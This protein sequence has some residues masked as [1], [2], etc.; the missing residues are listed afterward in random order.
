M[1]D[2]VKNYPEYEFYEEKIARRFEDKDKADAFLKKIAQG[3]LSDDLCV[4]PLVWKRG[5]PQS[6][7]EYIEAPYEL[8]IGIHKQDPKKAVFFLVNLKSSQSKPVSNS[9]ITP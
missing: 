6:N 8:K 4:K 3:E 9:I 2:D 1:S 7:R 5:N